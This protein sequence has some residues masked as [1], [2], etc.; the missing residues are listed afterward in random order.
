VSH[1]ADVDFNHW[2]EFE[3]HDTED[4]VD[5]EQL[6][7]ESKQS[8]SSASSSSSS[9]STLN[10]QSL[11][12]IH[13]PGWC[14]PLSQQS[15]WLLEELRRLAPRLRTCARQPLTQL[16]QRSDEYK[17]MIKQVLTMRQTHYL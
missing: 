11:S 3:S 4:D 17:E 2:P 14:L 12:S 16:Q 15:R 8:S 1:D 6:V 9:L 10:S 5:W 13:L 7:H